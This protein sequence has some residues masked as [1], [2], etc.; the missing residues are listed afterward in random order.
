MSGQIE[1]KAGIKEL[2]YRFNETRIIIS[3]QLF[4]LL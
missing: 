2:E 4:F 3:V 1:K